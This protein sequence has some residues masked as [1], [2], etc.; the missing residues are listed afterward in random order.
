MAFWVAG[1]LS[2][3][4]AGALSCSLAEWLNLNSG[5]LGF[6]SDSLDGAPGRLAGL[7]GWLG[8]LYG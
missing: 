8:F 2:C 4:L 6:L 3:W 7:S 5:W 1:F